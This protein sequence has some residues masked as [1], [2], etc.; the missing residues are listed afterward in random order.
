MLIL[1]LILLVTLFIVVLIPERIGKVMVL[2]SRLILM[3]GGILFM[4]LLFSLWFQ[5][6]AEPASKLREEASFLYKNYHAIG[7]MLI[8][9]FA[10]IPREWY[11]KTWKVLEDFRDS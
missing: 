2:V 9:C 11:I 1:L 5:L 8:L 3:V 7:I 4:A 6:L 10:S